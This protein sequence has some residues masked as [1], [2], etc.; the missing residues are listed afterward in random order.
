MPRLCGLL[1]DTTGDV[2]FRLDFRRDEGGR[3]VVTGEMSARLSLRCQRCLEEME[4]QVTETVDLALVTGIDEAQRLPDRY[5]PLLV[6]ENLIRPRDIIEDELLLN[7]PQIPKHDPGGCGL[8]VDSGS[9]PEAG[10]RSNDENPFAALAAI[11]RNN[12]R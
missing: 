6:E 3:A 8:E 11:R 10:V 9:H 1:L 2:V 4:H 5:E 12:K 7:L